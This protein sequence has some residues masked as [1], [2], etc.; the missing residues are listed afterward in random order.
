[1]QWLTADDD[2]GNLGNGTPHMTALFAAFER[3]GIACDSPTPQNSGCDGG[4]TNPP[5]VVAT[6][7]GN[8]RIDLRWNNVPDARRYAIFRTEGHAGCDLGKVR[9]ANTGGLSYSD[10]HLLPGRTYYYN[11][12]AVGDSAACLT[13]ASVCVSATPTP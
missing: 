12:M 5:V 4:P 11:V 2:D 13:P 10:R 9:I 6:D 8:G 7:R 1:M 3:H